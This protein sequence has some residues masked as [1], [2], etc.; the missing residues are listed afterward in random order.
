M[1]AAKVQHVASRAVDPLQ[2]PQPPQEE[3]ARRALP[4]R[5]AHRAH[6]GRLGAQG[7]VDDGL[8]VVPPRAAGRLG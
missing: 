1:N 2:L 7:E 4:E 3:E 8:L 5:R 6:V